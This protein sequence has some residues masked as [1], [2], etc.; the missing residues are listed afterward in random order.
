MRSRGGSL[1]PNGARHTSMD[2]K[3]TQKSQE[4]VSSAIRRAAAEGNPEVA[5]AHLFTS[6]LAQT[7]G[8]AVPLLEAVGADW[9]QLRTEAEKRLAALPKAQGSTVSA[10]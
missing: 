2:Y 9:K 10:P 4:A 5:P 7:G 8:T 3:L 1:P 6:L